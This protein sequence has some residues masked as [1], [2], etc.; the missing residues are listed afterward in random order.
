MVM[1]PLP[2]FCQILQQSTPEL[3]TIALTTPSPAPSGSKSSPWI[4]HLWVPLPTWIIDGQSRDLS[5]HNSPAYSHGSANKDNSAIGRLF[6]TSLPGV[7]KCYKKTHCGHLPSQSH[8]IITNIS[9]HTIVHCLSSKSL[10]WDSI[11]FLFLAKSFFIKMHVQVKLEWTNE[12]LAYNGDVLKHLYKRANDPPIA[13]LAH[14]GHLT[15]ELA[16]ISMI[17]KWSTNPHLN[18][19]GLSPPLMLPSENSYQV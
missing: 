7:Q 11:H 12:S 3:P 4:T 5:E 8:L 10:F 1:P 6:S 16:W 15:T 19:A 13:P 18:I 9:D 2:A 14:P 17:P